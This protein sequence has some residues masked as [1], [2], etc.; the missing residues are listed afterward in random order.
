V[1]VS[2][3]HCGDARHLCR[4]APS[5]LHARWRSAQARAAG[6]QSAGSTSAA[7]TLES[8]CWTA[9][10]AVQSSTASRSASASTGV[11]GK[12]ENC[13]AA[14]LIF[15]ARGGPGA[16]AAVLPCA[17]AGSSIGLAQDRVRSAAPAVS[18]AGRTEPASAD[19]PAR[20]GS[21]DLLTACNL[22]LQ[23]PHSRCL[24]TTPHRTPVPPSCQR[25]EPMLPLRKHNRAAP[26]RRMSLMHRCPELENFI[27]GGRKPPPVS[28][29]SALCFT[30]PQ[31][32]SGTQDFEPRPACGLQ[33]SR[34]AGQ[35]P[36]WGNFAS[37]HKKR[38]CSRD[39]PAPGVH[40]VS[41]CA[42]CVLQARSRRRVRR[43]RPVSQALRRPRVQA[44]VLH[45]QHDAVG[46]RDQAQAQLDR[47]A[48][49]QRGVAQGHRIQH[50]RTAAARC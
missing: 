20:T 49:D 17:P 48:R 29:C 50:L 30:R 23:F 34:P 12:R 2:T 38:A 3:S 22:V 10:L 7:S 43:Q 28:A 33:A 8:E 47:V 25:P 39:K 21:G 41:A 31:S 46:N 14:A 6:S 1:S 13:C 19:L 16:P 44:V 42:R 37:L 32:A 35:N 11:D 45:R 4:A 40:R 36:R 18:L 26:A 9:G 27:R 15:A 24:G 5:A